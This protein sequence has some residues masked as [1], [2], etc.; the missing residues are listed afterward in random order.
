MFDKILIANRAEIAARIIRGCDAMGIATVAVFS[1]EDAGGL[2]RRLAGEA[3]ALGGR[4]AAESYLD[5]EKIIAASLETG[6]QAVHPGYG[7]LSENADFAKACEA[8]GLTFIG[9]PADVIAAM[10]DKLA[11]KALAV[12]A[13]VNIIP[14]SDAVPGEAEAHAMA[15]EIGYPVMLKAAAGGGG[16]GMRIARDEAELAQGFASAAREAEAAFA[17]GRIFVEK[18]I[19]RPRHIEIQILADAHGNVVHL[20]ER[21]CSIQRRHQKIIEEAPSPLL[22]AK[23]RAAMGKQ[24]VAVARAVGYRSA[25]TVEF[26]ADAERNFYF[27]EMNTRLQVEHPVTEMVTGI[28][29]VE[30]MI[31]I[32]A[33]EPLGFTQKEIAATGWA[34]EARI[35]AEDPERG[36]LPSTGRLVRYREPRSELAGV[37][38]DSG[39]AEGEEIGIYYDPMLAKL[40]CHGPDRGQAIEGLRRALDQTYVRGLTHNIGFLNALLGHP[41]FAAGDLATDFIDQE[42]PDGFVRAQPHGQAWFDLVAVAACVHCQSVKAGT[43]EDLVVVPDGAPERGVPV[44]VV[45]GDGGTRVE[46]PDG[47]VMEV[48]GNWRP[49]Q[50]LF[51]GGIDGREVCIAVDPVRGRAGFAYRLVRGGHDVVLLVAPPH[52]AALLARMPQK[53]GADTH[54]AVTAPMPGLLVSLAVETGQAVKT[55]EQIAVIEAMKME[56]ILCAERDGTVA[57]LLVV[58]GESLA[59]DQVI[60][61]YD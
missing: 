3:V 52:I 31:R 21:E 49:G 11:A 44:R 20:N 28:D 18:Y 39:V 24:A 12:K 1:E 16:K 33:G 35:Y 22:D 47:E 56:N 38:I 37:R 54:H 6:A 29:L 53:A 30:A 40:I 23:T 26:I 4:T 42:W 61:E 8:A 14:G 59:V 41:R 2:P 9:P 15:A 50:P 13:G 32:A 55:G 34:I 17:D 58:P 25:G 43:H 57:R 45:A 7:F 46:R 60:L 48:Y 5:I 10:G 19:E 27:L 36:F 51:E